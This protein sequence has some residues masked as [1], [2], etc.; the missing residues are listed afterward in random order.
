MDFK[1]PRQTTKSK[2]EQFDLDETG[3]EI[4]I[5]SMAIEA[6]K[7]PEQ[8]AHIQAQGSQNPTT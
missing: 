1:K 4:A 6:D 2:F 3:E 8:L 5:A 7:N